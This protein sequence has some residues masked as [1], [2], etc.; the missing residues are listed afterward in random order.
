MKVDPTYIQIDMMSKKI[1]LRQR[2]LKMKTSVIAVA[3]QLYFAFAETQEANAADP[4]AIITSD[5][6]TDKPVARKKVCLSY[7]SKL[8]LWFGVENIK[9]IF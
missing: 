9:L 2:F 8:P 3:F 7:Y 5:V 1:L 6:P 4:T